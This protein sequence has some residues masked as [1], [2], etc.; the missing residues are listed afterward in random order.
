[1]LGNLTISF[2]VIP[3]S[4]LFTVRIIVIQK[5]SFIIFIALMKAV[6]NLGGELHLANA[7]L[8]FLKL[9]CFLLFSI[10]SVPVGKFQPK[11]A[12]TR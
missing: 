7:P 8:S 9:E 3:A 10:H 5:T 6:K 1:M 4:N 2:A 12:P 11:I